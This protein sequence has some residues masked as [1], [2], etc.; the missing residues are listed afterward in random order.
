MKMDISIYKI[1]INSYNRYIH[2]A[3][4]THEVF[5]FP[6]PKWAAG[7]RKLLCALDCVNSQ[8]SFLKGE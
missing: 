2:T 8:P 3:I 1:S 7:I 6:D 4:I 5:L